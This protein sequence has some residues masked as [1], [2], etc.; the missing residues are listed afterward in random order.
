MG[1]LK[2]DI[3]S[4]KWSALKV[5]HRVDLVQE[6]RGVSWMDYGARWYDPS[7]GRFTS[8]D[9]FVQDFSFQTPFAY[10]ANDPIKFIDVNGDSVRVNGNNG[11]STFYFP[12][13]TYDGDSEYIS[14][15]FDALN[16]LVENGADVCD[17]IC[18][19]SYAD[20]IVDIKDNTRKDNPLKS[21][22]HRQSYF[23]PR[24][25]TLIWDS[26]MG[27]QFF[28]GSGITIRSPEEV[29]NHEMGHAASFLLNEEEHNKRGDKPNA[30]YGDEEE[31]RVITQIE[32]PSAI[33][34]NGNSKNKSKPRNNHKGTFT[35]L[36]KLRL[37]PKKRT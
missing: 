15:V 36:G 33:I 2:L 8:I 6:K 3:G 14:M 12:G 11:E 29:L 20:G 34:L 5:V 25:S 4:N 18:G 32:N 16:Y 37:W 1:C 21:N 31:K 17:Q 19:T 26:E 13:A 35:K 30:Q 7:V 27:S 22:G 24:T 23:N 9:R 28:N 10:A